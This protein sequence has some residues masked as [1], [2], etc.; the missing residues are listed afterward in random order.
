MAIK[1][2][3]PW[4]RKKE[5]PVRLEDEHPFAS[6]QREMNRMFD[7]FFDPGF[8]LEPFGFGESR[9]G[10]FS[11]RINVAE[12]EKEVE[13]S[14]ELPGMDKKDIDVA[15]SNETLTIK[16]EKKEEKEEKKRGY[17]RMERSYGSFQRT[18]PL[19]VGIDE[20]KAN[21]EFRKG[22]LT[23]TLPKT[24]EAQKAAKKIPITTG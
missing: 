14:V 21:A 3:I 13:V 4:K 5:V 18:I 1:D 11:P 17:Y 10:A 9:L 15:I 16:G 20:A 19:P 12:K 6:L 8:N 7:N 23:I 22:V 2:L 24:K